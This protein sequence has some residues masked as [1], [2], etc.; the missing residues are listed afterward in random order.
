MKIYKDIFSGDELFSDI[1][2][3]KEIHGGEILKVQGKLVTENQDSSNIDI[4][5]NASEEAPAEEAAE[6][7]SKTGVNIVMANR[8]E[9]YKLDKKKALKDYLLTYMKDLKERLEADEYKGMDS[10]KKN[11]QA[12]VVEVLGE[13]KEYQFFMGESMAHNGML[14]LMRWDGETPYMYFFKQGCLEEK[15]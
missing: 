7:T 10:F 6:A 9:E 14:A 15:V 2:P 1:Y 12:F 4:G 3:I 5:A 13:F 8:L 11:C